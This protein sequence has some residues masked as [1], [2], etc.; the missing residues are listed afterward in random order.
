MLLGCGLALF[1]FCW[2]R[3][4]V[5]SQISMER[6]QT[7]FEQFREFERFSPIPFD[8]LFSYEGRISLGFEELVVFLCM[9]IWAI[10]RGSDCVSG[11][12]NR[13]TMELLL[14]QPVSRSQVFWSQALVTICG[15]VALAAIAWGGVYAGI[16]CG[17]IEE[18]PPTPG[19]D[20][21]L[22]GGEFTIPNPFAKETE[23]TWIPMRDRVAVAMFLPAVMNFFALG[24][25]LSGF[26]ALMS[27][28]DQY[29]WRTLGL[30]AAFYVLQIALEIGSLSTPK[31]EWM[32]W[33]TVLTAYDPAMLTCAAVDQPES[34]WRWGIYDANGEFKAW[35]G[36]ARNG[37]LVG[38]GM[39]CYIGGAWIF[40]KRDLPAPT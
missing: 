29:R 16:Q 30:I 2:L 11:E 35:S 38:L 1:L 33:F 4:W 13:G 26:S 22:L 12:L 9:S 34:L 14:S 18:K 27:S 24:F 7:V 21:S 8:R 6:F 20:I 25:F 39:V 5:V 19:W 15:V 23:S 40:T 10:A 31:L 37:V 3:T 36:L 32:A 28:W 17:W